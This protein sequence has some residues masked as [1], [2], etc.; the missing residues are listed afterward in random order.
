MLAWDARLQQIPVHYPCFSLRSLTEC[1]R[2]H[3]P[4]D[5]RDVNAYEAMV[6]P[7][8]EELQREANLEDMARAQR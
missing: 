6:L 5:K 2:T 7:L 3:S 4:D 1:P 8:V